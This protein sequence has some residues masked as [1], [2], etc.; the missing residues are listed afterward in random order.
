M[1]HSLL[2][3]SA[4]IAALATFLVCPSSGQEK[5]P[6][7]Q[8]KASVWMEKKREFT[9]NILVALTQADFA[10][11][12]RNAENMNF[13]GYLEKWER[14]GA[15]PDYK[16][17]MTYFEFANQELIR[18]AKEKNID[19][20]TLAFNPLTTSCVQCHKVVRDAKK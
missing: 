18:H 16:R 13:V 2:A 17:Q 8:E 9:Q 6:V 19:G 12:E 15:R 1:K 5:K 4:V 10:E 3:M 7:K 20:A 14:G 11:I